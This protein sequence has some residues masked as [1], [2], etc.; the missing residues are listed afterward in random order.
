[1]RQKIK[2]VL[3]AGVQSLQQK[4]VKNSIVVEPNLI[5]K[6][7]NKRLELLEKKLEAL[8]VNIMNLA[9]EEIKTQEYVNHNSTLFEI[10]L[11]QL[12]QG[13]IAFVKLNRGPEDF[14]DNGDFG[15]Q[16]E[17]I[18]PSQEAKK[19]SELN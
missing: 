19:K 7:D 10:I 15:E 8:T 16:S 14:T 9:A 5:S 12:D 18:N 17:E 13:N 3:K 2:A 1:M 4:F 11:N 6:I